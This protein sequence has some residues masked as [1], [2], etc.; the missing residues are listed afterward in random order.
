MIQSKSG[1]RGKGNTYLPKR[2]NTYLRAVTI[3]IILLVLLLPSGSAQEIQI[4]DIYSDIDMAD[5]TIQSKEQYSDLTINADLIF[6]GEVISS[7]QLFINEITPDCEII[8]VASWDVTNT[9]DGAY[10]A[11]MTLSENSKVLETKYYNFSYGWEALP[12]IYIKDMIPDSSGVSVILT[13]STTQYGSNPV[14]TDIEYMLI[15]GDTAIY[16]TRDRRI[17]VVQAT[18]LSEDW[19]VLLENNHPYI[20]RIKL[21]ISSPQDTVIARSEGFTAKDNARITE[22]Y[23]DETGA[24]VTVKGRSQVPFTGSLVFTVFK[25]GE[26]IEEIKE[27]SPIL[28]SG[29]DETTEVTWSSRLPTGIYDLSVTVGGND[30]DIVDKWDTIIESKEDLYDHGQNESESTEPTETPGFGIHLT[31]I[32]ILVIYLISGRILHRKG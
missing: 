13:P 24:S 20:S 17:S 23:E 15:D 6:D 11:R 27:Q 8:K 5:I 22:L 21:R 18:P 30:K 16:R 12:R 25:D 7:K 28:M 9:K 4:T 14:L 1:K 31:I 19:N 10:C 3:G 32:S 26:T 29:D 2:E